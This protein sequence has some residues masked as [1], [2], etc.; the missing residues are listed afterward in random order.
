MSF[1]VKDITTTSSYEFHLGQPDKSSTQE[2]AGRN[3]D[4]MKLL[5]MLRI[6]FADAYE[7]QM[8]HNT[9]SIKAPRRLSIGEIAQC[10]RM[11]RTRRMRRS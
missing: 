7:V 11:H 10:R 6:K 9:Y 3:M 4:P 2:I 8:M 5:A 1:E